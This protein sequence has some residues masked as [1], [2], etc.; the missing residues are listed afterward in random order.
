MHISYR[1]AKIGHRTLTIGR[2]ML[3]AHHSFDHRHR[4]LER[5]GIRAHLLVT[6]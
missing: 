1:S 4:S 3:G 6:R 2:D 5:A